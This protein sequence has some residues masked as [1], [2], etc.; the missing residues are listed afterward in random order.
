MWLVMNLLVLAINI[1][2]LALSLK[3]YTEVLKDSAMN[4]RAIPSLQATGSKS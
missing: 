2:V 3:L 4:R 1:G